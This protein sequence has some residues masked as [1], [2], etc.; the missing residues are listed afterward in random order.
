MGMLRPLPLRAL[1]SCL[2]RRRGLATLGILLGCLPVAAAVAV[3]TEEALE[4]R[5]RALVLAGGGP[6][7]PG[8]PA[9]MTPVMSGKAARVFQQTEGLPPGREP[10]DFTLPDTSGKAVTLSSFRGKRP[11][12]LV[13][14]S[15]G[16]NLFCDSLGWLCRLRDA[17]RG[18]A[19]FLF[20]YVSEAPHNST[21]L[22]KAARPIPSPTGEDARLQRVRWYEE[23][24]GGDLR[25]LLDG[26]DER[27]EELYGA[28]PRRLVIVGI[29]G[30][31]VFDAGHGLMRPWDEAEIERHL[32]AALPREEVH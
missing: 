9:P 25:W 22:P 11:V 6:G 19:E 16:C 13:F 31:V 27:V 32:W 20:V 28:W 7:G 10:P 12:V 30:R 15:F 3:V 4:A 8:V 5:R 23:E 24:G 2:C 26:A 18:R 17:S 1:L 14:G 29:D 21:P